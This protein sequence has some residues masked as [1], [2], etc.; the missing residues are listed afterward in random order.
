M[1]LLNYKNVHF[2]LILKKDHPL[3]QDRT[4]LIGESEESLLVDLG[5][6]VFKVKDMEDNPEEEKDDYIILEDNNTDTP[7]YD[8][9]EEKATK[10]REGEE[11]KGV[12][13]KDSP[14]YTCS[15]CKKKTLEKI[16]I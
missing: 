12:R 10:E 11:E 8:K 4:L 9:E 6:E 15:I 14:K 5:E 16:L 13:A 3:V 7:V 1:I 2:N